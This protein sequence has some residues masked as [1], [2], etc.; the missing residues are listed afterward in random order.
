ML[1]PR[2]AALDNAQLGRYELLARL[3]VGGMAEIYLARAQGMSGFEKLLVLKRILPQHALDPELL[4]MF[5]DE[6]RLSATLTHP[7]ITQVYDIG[8]QGDT[9]FFTME[10]VH[11]ANLREI[12]NTQATVAGGGGGRALPDAHA[13]SIIAAAA[14]GLHYAHERR[15]ADGQPLQIVHRDVSPSNVLVTYDGAVK[16]ADFG[17]AKWA[18]QRTQTQAGAL[19]GKFAYMSPEQCRSQPVDRRSDVFAL[20]TLLYE[21][22]TGTPPFRGDS[23]YEILTHIVNDAAPAPARPAGDYPP[24]LARIVSRALARAPEDR[25]PTA[26]ALQVDLETFARQH[27]LSLSSVALGDFMRTLFADRMAA[28]EAAQRAGQTLGQHLRAA[29]ADPAR[30]AAG[31]AVVP[32]ATDVHLPEAG[33]PAVADPGATPTARRPPGLRAAILT[34][35]LFVT[36]AGATIINGSSS[37]PGDGAAATT[38]VDPPARPAT[39]PNPTTTTPPSER[40]ASVSTAARAPA[41]GRSTGSAPARR[42]LKRSARAHGTP[43]AAPGDRGGHGLGAWDPDSP[44]PP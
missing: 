30:A 9:P 23:D 35:I 26:Q 34:G 3:A 41:D 16:V 6:A 39:N 37:R 7:H 31:L 15:G 13:V 25:Y 14:A 36:A 8:T 42:R 21:L 40:Q 38:P 4:R 18:S 12:L 17:I 5:L 1:Q 11:G 19:K 22:T 44:V 43:T 29:S 24:D 27:Q 32:T 20:G 2:D 33:E 10:Y 28:W